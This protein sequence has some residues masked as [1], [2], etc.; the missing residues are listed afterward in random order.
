MRAFYCDEFVLPL[1]AGHRFP[2]RK[3]SELRRRL[4]A[5]GV[6]TPTRLHV[7]DAATD[8]ELLRAH[9][10]DY[11]RRVVEGRLD[12]ADVRRLGF[13]WSPAMVERS[14][15]SVGGTIAAARSALEQG[16]AVNLAGGTHHAFADRGEGFCVFNDAAVAAHAMLAQGRAHRIAIVDCDVHQGN[17]TAAIFAGDPRVFTFSIHGADNYP[18]AKVP[19]DLDIALADGTGD[20]DYL[21]RLEQ[22]LDDTLRRARPQL[23]VYLAGA[24]PYAGDRYGRLALSMEGLRRRDRA[25]LSACAGRGI[26][27]AVTM[28]G[29]YAHVDDVVAI[30][31]ATV[32]EAVRH[33]AERAPAL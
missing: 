23:V 18:F 30:H 25:V 29:G 3:Y 20:D 15:R 16:V 22:G 19:G 31:E 28:A 5:D 32:R 24:D 14:R 12:P 6:L 10:R 9:S 8:E 27:V 26:A 17:G 21:E 4:V 2:M 7:P 1:P 33:A 13:P 11:L